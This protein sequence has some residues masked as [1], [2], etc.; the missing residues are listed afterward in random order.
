[1][2]IIVSLLTAICFIAV[3]QATPAPKPS[4]IDIIP[5]VSG[6]AVSSSATPIASDVTVLSADPFGC[7][8]PP[9]GH[10]W[11]GICFR[12]WLRPDWVGDLAASVR[13]L[14]TRWWDAIGTRA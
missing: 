12:L 6:S 13:W 4:T 3:A 5:P 7:Q 1:M 8:S 14:L 11:E 2:R 10:P 9:L